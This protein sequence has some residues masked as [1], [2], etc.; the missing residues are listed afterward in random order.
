MSGKPFEPGRSGNPATQWQPGQSGNPAGKPKAR[1]QFEEALANALASEIRGA[2]EGI[3]G[4]AMD[5]GAQG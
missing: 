1:R 5:R 2:R 3:G 4:A